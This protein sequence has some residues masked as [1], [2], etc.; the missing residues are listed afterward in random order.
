MFHFHLDFLEGEHFAEAWL[1]GEPACYYLVPEV[2]VVFFPCY[3]KDR[4]CLGESVADFVAV[5]ASV[6]AAVAAMVV[7]E[8]CPAEFFVVDFLVFFQA[9][10]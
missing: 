6:M 1:A 8:H 3:L 7:V 5:V 2:L 9:G 4:V 10:D